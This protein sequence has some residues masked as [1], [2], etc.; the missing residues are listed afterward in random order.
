M[1]RPVIVAVDRALEGTLRA[2]LDG[3]AK[4]PGSLG[5]IEDLAVQLGLIAAVSPRRWTT[6]CCWSSPAIT[7]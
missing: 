5:R 6:S 4:P 7:G 3:K 1:E 2:R